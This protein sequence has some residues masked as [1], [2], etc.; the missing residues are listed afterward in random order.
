MRKYIVYRFRRGGGNVTLQGHTDLVNAIDDII[1][2]GYVIG[3]LDHLT[4][5]PRYH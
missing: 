3:M 1:G 4:G 2:V 5:F